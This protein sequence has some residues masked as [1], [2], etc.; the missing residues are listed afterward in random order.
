MSRGRD[1][2]VNAYVRNWP[3]EWTVEVNGK[4]GNILE[5]DWRSEESVEDVMSRKYGVFPE[6]VK[7]HY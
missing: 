3:Y 2:G 4:W 5:R 7:V 1:S 6:N